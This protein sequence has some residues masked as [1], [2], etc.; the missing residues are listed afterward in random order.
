MADTEAPPVAIFKKRTNKSNLR[1]RPASPPPASDGSSSSE[2]D[3]SEDESGRKI[4]RPRKTGVSGG[5]TLIKPAR[6]TDTS[7]T[8]QYVAD[9]SA[10]IA[11]SDDATR[12][13]NWYDETAPDALSAKNLLGS[14]RA[15]GTTDTP[16]GTYKG[17][18]GYSS[19]I[20]K[21]PEARR[22]GPVKEASTNVRTITITDYA[23]DVCKD[24]KQTGFCGFG[25]SCKF[26]H[27]R[28]DYA[29]GWKLDRDWEVTNKGKKNLGGTVISSANK[30]NEIDVDK[31]AEEAAML[32][33]IPFA[34][35]ICKESYKSPVVTKCGHYFCEKCALQRYKKNPNCVACGAGTNGVFNS[36]R[37]L[38]K[39][40]DRKRTREEKLQEEKEKEE[41][42]NNDE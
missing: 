15:A 3:Y 38:Q 5:S 42:E 10:T 34:C 24:Y 7:A 14:S 37:S 27:A 18:A 33:K 23:P 39:L 12:Q 9:R 16:D 29:Q 35:I 26:L 2:A 28:E 6:K 8:T 1:K 4:K 17:Q 11:I 40:L 36:A 21:N 20:S 41:N 19:F 32:E 13:S 31:E 22:A 30:K 25:D